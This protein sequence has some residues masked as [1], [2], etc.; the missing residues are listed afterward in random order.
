MCL[1][2]IDSGGGIA[3]EWKKHTVRLVE[4]NDPNLPGK[5]KLEGELT[6]KDVTVILLQNAVGV[7]LERE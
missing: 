5:Y 6:R 4:I 7:R 3:P 2:I 1:T